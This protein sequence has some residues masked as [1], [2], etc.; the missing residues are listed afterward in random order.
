MEVANTKNQEEVKQATEIIHSNGGC[1]KNMLCD[2]CIIKK[3]KG[4]VKGCNSTTALETANK[5]MASK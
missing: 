5:F 2:Y 1:P 3:I 4:T